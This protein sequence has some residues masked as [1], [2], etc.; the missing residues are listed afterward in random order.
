MSELYRIY[1]AKDKKQIA[2]FSYI[3]AG[4]E[5]PLDYHAELEISLFMNVGGV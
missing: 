4:G 5:S 1:G 3:Q 2:I